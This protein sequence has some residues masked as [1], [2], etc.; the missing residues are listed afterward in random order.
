MN[1]LQEIVISCLKAH[2]ISFS[3][4]V[5]CKRN[6]DLKDGDMIVP[7]GLT[8]PLSDQTKQALKDELMQ[9][10]TEFKWK[11][12]GV[13]SPSYCLLAFHFHKETMYRCTLTEL[14]TSDVLSR[15][16]KCIHK[17]RV[18]VNIGFQ[19]SD[20]P[21]TEDLRS[22]ILLQHI[23][24]LLSCN[25]YDVS[26]IPVPMSEERKTLSKKIGLDPCQ[27]CSDKDLPV[28][29]FSE[30]VDKHSLQKCRYLVYRVIP[31][32][33]DGGKGE[34][35]IVQNSEAIRNYESTDCDLSHQTMTEIHKCLG[36][37][38]EKSVLVVGPC[39]DDVGVD[40]DLFMEESNIK[41][42]KGNYEKSIKRVFPSVSIREGP[43]TDIMKEVLNLQN[44]LEQ[45][46]GG[47]VLHLNSEKR[48]YHQQQVDLLWK[49]LFGDQNIQ[50]VHINYNLV[51]S[52]QGT[53]VQKLVDA[54][55]F[56][57]IRFQQMKDAAIV[58]YG[59]KVKGSNWEDTIYSLT[60]ASLKFEFLMTN[61][62]NMV[63]LDLSQG[64]EFGGGVDNRAGAFVMYNCARLSTLF[65]HFEDN[66][67][68]GVYPPLPDISHIDFS[69]LREE[70][71]WELFYNYIFVY[72]DLIVETTEQF[73]PENS[74]I[75]KIQTHKVC[76][77][78]IGLSRHLSSY[79]SRTHV[80]G[81]NRTHLLPTMYARLYLL[82]II[83]GM[84][85]H[86]LHQLGIVPLNQL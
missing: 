53:N 85:C 27:I 5:L 24:N 49:A 83:H 81:E 44:S 65:K 75:S 13:T 25:G 42:G 86:G 20:T 9:R 10:L 39:D 3:S 59:D 82:K 1:D 22:V 41:I 32:Q 34:N 46:A 61:H 51:T 64:Q 79:Y 33:C 4:L 18:W 11:C 40:L 56:L 21:S 70:D 26:F 63:K 80:L 15:K 38:K 84:M 43:C 74:I 37:T 2:N 71:E 67:S 76:N 36:W 30:I 57:S 52:R 19:N 35:N 28:Q 45:T 68:K 47:V 66:V 16:S 60:V 78:L 48:F 17:R 62:R 6:R 55:E 8:Q 58:K 73:L 31:V 72:P 54:D 50:Q 14:W 77:F 12:S 69:T 23:I 29:S 7:K